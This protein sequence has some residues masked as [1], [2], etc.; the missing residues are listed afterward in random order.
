MLKQ[1][2]QRNNNIMSYELF[3]LDF[4]QG[5]AVKN[6]VSGKVFDDSK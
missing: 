5:E 2:G 4:F 1:A 6:V 3:F